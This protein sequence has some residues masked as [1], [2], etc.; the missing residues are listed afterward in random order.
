MATPT[1]AAPVAPVDPIAEAEAAAVDKAAR[2]DPSIGH[3]F[4]KLRTSLKA[5][6]AQVAEKDALLAK[7][8]ADPL[9][10]GA[11][12][13][14]LAK[15]LEEK[16]KLVADLEE[17]IE[18]V[19]LEASPKFQAKYDR[20]IQGVGVKLAQSLSQFASVD[21]AE[22]PK[23]AAAL[24]QADTKMLDEHLAK[25]SPSIG[26]IVMAAWQEARGLQIEK[27]AALTEAKKTS[28]A[29]QIEQVQTQTAEQI[30]ERQNVAAAALEASVADGCFVYRDL[31]TPESKASAENYRNAFLGFVQTADPKELIRKAADGFAAPTLF[32]VM[33]LQ[34]QRIM[35]LEQQLGIRNDV[36]RMPIST[37]GDPAP[38]PA[39]AAPRFRGNSTAERRDNAAADAA[40]ALGGR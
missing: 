39:P 37:G 2:F 6:L 13:S 32:R 17:K 21:A 10:T 3:T 9:A 19:N 20:R 36:A 40:A 18:R 25:M 24:L 5:A 16:E 28:A 8:A 30:R 31:G 26:G 22:A 35:D 34:R 11:D 7:A 14:A 38:V 33:G 15:Q 12:R 29:M 4:A 1:P 27:N 23:L